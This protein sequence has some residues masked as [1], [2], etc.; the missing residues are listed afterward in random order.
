[1]TRDREA[2]ARAH[3]EAA[4]SLALRELIA[5]R[6]WVVWQYEVRA[7]KPTKV[8]Y[9]PTTRQRASSTDPTTWSAY[10]EA[11]AVA[12]AY[13]GLGCVIVT[14]YT[15]LDLDKCRDPETGALAPWARA[16]VDRLRSYTET[17]PSGRG[18]HVWMKGNLPPGRRRRGP[19]EMYDGGRYFT[20][21]GA[22]LPGTPITI[23]AR[24]AE[25]EGLHTELFGALTHE[26]APS[27]PSNGPLTLDDAAV[28]DVILRSRAGAKFAQLWGG[29]WVAL[30]YALTERGRPRPL[31]PAGVSLR[32]R[33]GAGGSPLSALATPSGEVGPPTRRRDLWR[34][35]DPAGGGAMPG[36][37]HG[38]ERA[39]VI[40]LDENGRSSTAT[41]EAAPPDQA[42]G[43]WPTLAAEAR[44]GLAGRIVDAI[45]PYSEAD[46]AALLLHMLVGIGSLVGPG[47]HALVE[48]T[49]HPARLDAAFVGET[50]KGRKGQSWSTPRY[51]L[52]Q[53]DAPWAQHRVRTGLVS[54]E[55]LIYH[56]RD[57]RWE[58][59]PIREK[60]RVID[61]QD[62]LADAGEPDKRL[63]VIEPEFGRMLRTMTRD[64]NTLS[65]VL[66]DA[67]DRGDL[68]TLA[69]NAPLRATGAHVSL[70]GHITLDELVRDLTQTD[71]ADGFANR[72][73]WVLVRRSKA[74]PFSEGAPDSD[75]APLVAE[76]RA[77]A[78][79]ARTIDRV[80]FNDDAAAVWTD[81][82]PALGE[83]GPGLLGHVLAR[84]EAQTL[85]LSVLFA[86]LDQTPWIQPPHLEA[87]L[88]IWEY[89]RPTLRPRSRSGSTVRRRPA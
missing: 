86:V 42:G 19:V 18:V 81:V 87:A 14:P 88:A 31:L 70:I 49:P 51:L 4:V 85:R 79:M 65:A 23:E 30:G 17:S 58:R 28:I 64:A 47:P 2:D 68:S 80:R 72:I 24:Q 76:L 71:Q 84:A 53:V 25:L 8:P 34:V 50:A 6:R 20:I 32:A 39:S 37:L 43:A 48:R 54:G 5:L 45:E 15:G 83:A 61:Y 36:D 41:V 40:T 77:G 55:G 67:W 12:S 56:V 33:C 21:T 7:G 59:Q 38:G 52:S 62:V 75:L 73:L 63:L 26:P 60:G 78:T 44:Y 82:Y 69:K 74:L 66:R 1:V 35:D 29:E 16:M 46:P 10:D 9:C 11:A 89:C 3:E 27:P 57:E 13:A 22:H